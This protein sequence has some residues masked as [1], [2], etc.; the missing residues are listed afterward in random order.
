MEKKLKFGNRQTNGVKKTMY[1]QTKALDS[2]TR[3]KNHFGWLGRQTQRRHDVEVVGLKVHKFLA[4]G[5]KKD[6]V[7]DVDSMAGTVKKKVRRRGNSIGR[8]KTSVGVEDVLMS[9]L[10]NVDRVRPTHG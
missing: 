7:V 3:R 5:P 9:R 10:S 2:I 4:I 6:E 8:K 1:L